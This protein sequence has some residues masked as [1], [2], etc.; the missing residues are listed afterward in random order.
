MRRP[1]LIRDEDA[2]RFPPPSSRLG[3][4][5]TRRAV[6]MLADGHDTRAIASSLRCREAAVWNAVAATKGDLR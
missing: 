1:N 2:R 5:S 4:F 6:E 3:P